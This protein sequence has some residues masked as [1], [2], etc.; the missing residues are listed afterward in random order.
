MWDEKEGRCMEKVTIVYKG[1]SIVK[2]EEELTNLYVGELNNVVVEEVS[3]EL[4]IYRAIIELPENEKQKFLERVKEYFKDRDDILSINDEEKQERSSL[5]I[6]VKGK[7]TAKAL[8]KFYVKALKYHYPSATVKNYY[9]LVTEE[10]MK[11][12]LENRFNDSEWTGEIW[13][14]IKQKRKNIVRISRYTWYKKERMLVLSLDCLPV[15]KQKEFVKKAKQMLKNK[16]Q[17]QVL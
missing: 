17:I 2:V 10:D 9:P 14:F 8:L 12:A 5:E 1:S 6:A 16:A 3:W 7:D 4:D 13:M 15:S 11:L